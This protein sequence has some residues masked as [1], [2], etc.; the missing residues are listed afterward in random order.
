MRFFYL[1][2]L[3]YFLFIITN[4]H[5]LRS[6]LNYVKTIN[7]YRLVYDE[8][9]KLASSRETIE[10]ALTIAYYIFELKQNKKQKT[11]ITEN[12]IKIYEIYRNE[13]FVGSCYNDAI[14]FN[15]LAKNVNINSRIIEL[16]GP[17]G[18]GGKGHTIN[19]FYSDEYKKWVMIDVNLGIM[20]FD[21][22]KVP[23]SAY[24]VRKMALSSKNVD[25]FLH[26]VILLKLNG[27]VSKNTIYRYYFYNSKEFLII[28]DDFIAKNYGRKIAY[29]FED[30]NCEFCVKFGRFL[31][32]LFSPIFRIRIKDEYSPKI[33]YRIYFWTFQFIFATFVFINIYYLSK[34]IKSLFYRGIWKK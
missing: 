5:R 6:S 27:N 25:E 16:A 31:R 29:F 24:E 21:F 30:M 2:F 13:N 23:L 1:L 12:P 33:Y 9:I 18:L 28:E 15:F 14:L 26:N 17:D 22:N 34:L 4:H 10:K 7:D 32:S 3:I 11:W 19:E 20:F 8:D